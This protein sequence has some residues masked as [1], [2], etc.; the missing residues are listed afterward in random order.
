MWGVLHRL[1]LGA[2]PFFVAA[3]W[4]ERN[5]EN[6]AVCERAVHQLD[7]WIRADMANTSR[8]INETELLPARAG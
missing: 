8:W 7:G 3:D 5:P 6:C 4:A 1:W 2:S